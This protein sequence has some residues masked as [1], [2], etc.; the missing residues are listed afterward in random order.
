M[1]ERPESSRCLTL[2]NA[3]N[4]SVGRQPTC[5]GTTVVKGKGCSQKA[6]V[7]EE[8]VQASSQME[9]VVR[10]KICKVNKNLSR[11]E[12]VESRDGNRSHLQQ[13]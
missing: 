12:L 7:A 1:R 10:L 13:V 5:S 2:R 11:A 4:D 6:E 3:G 8:M 9:S